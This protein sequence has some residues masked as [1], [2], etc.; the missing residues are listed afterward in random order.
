MLQNRCTCSHFA[1]EEI[2][3]LEDYVTE[4]QQHK[5]AFLWSQSRGELH[6]Y[7]YILFPTVQRSSLQSICEAVHIQVHPE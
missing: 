1:D 3:A 5:V 4:V 7:V 2:G 6:Q